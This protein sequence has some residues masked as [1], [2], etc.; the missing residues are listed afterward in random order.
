MKLHHWLIV[1]GL[2]VLFLLLTLAKS[3]LYEDYKANH[4]VSGVRYTSGGELPGSDPPYCFE[5]VAYQKGEA[6]QTAILMYP[7]EIQTR[8]SQRC[9]TS[10]GRDFEEP[11]LFFSICG[12]EHKME[13]NRVYLADSNDVATSAPMGEVFSQPF[14]P[15]NLFEGY[16]AELLDFLQNQQAER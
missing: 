7:R 3:A 12:H 6:W 4:K 13:M 11:K 8:C 9:E 15:D 10:Y 16:Q 5:T 2:F 14:D 1:F